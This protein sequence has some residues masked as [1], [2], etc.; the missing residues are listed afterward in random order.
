MVE[1]ANSAEQTVPFQV[2]D[3]ERIPTQRYYDEEFYKLEAEKLW[4]HVWQM[5]CRLEQIPEVG[6]WIEYSNLG[7]SVIVVRTKDGVKA[8]HNACRH[9]GVPLTEGTS[10]N[11]KGKGFICPFHGWCWNLDGTNSFVYQ[12]ELFSD[13]VLDP[14]E[15]RLVECQVD[16]WAGCV[17]VNMDADA[18]PLRATLGSG[19]EVTEINQQSL[20]I[21]G[22]AD[23][24]TLAKVS[25][26]CE[27]QGVL[28]ES[29]SLGQ[30]TL[31]DVFLQITGRELAP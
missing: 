27:E 24:S 21:T 12:P 17:F 2:T 22:P 23:A 11:C 9:R 6:D 28:P 13:A 29:L 16:T 26:W 30:R 1:V 18:P 3:P 14:D 15:L 4:P 8:F 31:E 25:A 5:A 19:T 7:K 20:L 10:G